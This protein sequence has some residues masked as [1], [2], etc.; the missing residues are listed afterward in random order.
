MPSNSSSRYVKVDGSY[1]INDHLPGSHLV[2]KVDSNEHV[3]VTIS[4]RP[5]RL[6]ELQ[7]LVYD[8]SS[9]L[10][11][12]RQY[13]T[14]NDLQS[15]YGESPQN[16]AHVKEF[17]ERHGLEVLEASALKRAVIVG[18]TAKSLCSAFRT[19]LRRYSYRGLMYRGRKGWINVPQN[20]APIIQG[21]HG[22]DNRPQ[23]ISSFYQSVQSNKKNKD[24]QSQVHKHLFTPLEI[25]KL[26]YFPSMNIN[27]KR[28][29]GSGQCMAMIELGGGFYRHYIN[30]YFRDLKVTIPKI[31]CEPIG[32]VKNAPGN[33]DN[34][35]G[36][37][38]I[39]IAIAGAVAP[40]AKLVI[41]FSDPTPKGFFDAV[42]QAVHDTKHKSSIIFITSGAA[43]GWPK[44][45]QWLEAMNQSFMDAA[46]LG[47]TIICATGDYGSSDLRPNFEDKTISDHFAHVDF[48]ASS[49][50]AL[51]CG[52]T[53][54]ISSDGVMIRNEIAWNEG[55]DGATG[56]GVS[57]HFKRPKYQDGIGIQRSVNK[58]QTHGRCVPD[59]AGFASPGYN[60]PVHGQEDPKGRRGTSAVVPLWAGLI[61]LINQSIGKPVGFI[62]PLLYEHPAFIGILSDITKGNNRI[63]SA[64]VAGKGKMN[65]DGYNARKGWDACTGLGTPNGLKLLNALKGNSFQRTET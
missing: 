18:G 21:V 11:N 35:D 22:L 25:A 48:P 63:R 32:G 52:G 62:N 55:R 7:A 61:A 59:V 64:K 54:L 3:E 44:W 43:E 14:V 36:E 12:E 51:A 33:D 58:R 19:K 6:K 2:G 20:L 27:G 13:I 17:S 16:L 31:S 24:A 4:I 60:I 9:R 5:R 30:A 38:M 49:P 53:K 39:D 50:F 47:K 28:L 1:R 10:P 37:V 42:N 40:G 57:E 29:D 15:R 41:Y 8:M 56:G 34:K 46:A 65:V 23:F 26:Y 45:G